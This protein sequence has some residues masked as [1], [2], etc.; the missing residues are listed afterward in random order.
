M[1]F[2]YKSIRARLNKRGLKATPQRL[3]VLQALIAMENHP[4]TEEIIEYVVSKNPAI[5]QATIYRALDTLA[6]HKIIN[7]IKTESGRMRFDANTEPHF[8]L[9]DLNGECIKDYSDPELR[10]YLHDYFEKKGIPSFT[11][12]EIK[13]QLIGQ[14][15]D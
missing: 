1:T 13:L 12:S 14:I 15:Q 10:E 5:S 3:A 11:L 2:D 7:R 6:D 9:Y 4:D 8:H